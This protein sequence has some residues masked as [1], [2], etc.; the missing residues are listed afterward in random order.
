M[1]K[2]PLPGK[3]H[4][5]QDATKSL[6][7]FDRLARKRLGL[8]PPEKLVNPS[9]RRWLPPLLL[10]FLVACVAGYG[11][12]LHQK[13]GAVA[14]YP[15]PLLVSFLDVGQ[16]DSAFIQT[17]S[18]K[19]LLIDTGPPSAR[20]MLF[21]ELQQRGVK[22]LDMLITLHP[23]RDHYGNT[24]AVLQR[25]PTAPVVDSGFVKGSLTQY[26]LPYLPKCYN[27]L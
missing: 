16:G 26:D 11:F 10:L 9:R 13:R 17:P 1:A 22:R 3:H 24:L 19:N 14:P 2:K 27:N 21:A 4:N 12:H 5:L 18:G 20:S 25:I 7:D 15:Q 6:D 23:D 8:P